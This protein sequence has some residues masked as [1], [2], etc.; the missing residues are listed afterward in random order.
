M[1]EYLEVLRPLLQG[2]TV[3]H[4]GE[5]YTAVGA[6]DLPGAQAPSVLIAALGPAMLYSMPRL[7]RG[8]SWAGSP[9][10]RSPG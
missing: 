5:T 8:G 7:R 2:E 10:A 4:H 9:T 1:R 6:I 3:D